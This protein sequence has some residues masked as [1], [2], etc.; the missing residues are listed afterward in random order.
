MYETGIGGKNRTQHALLQMLYNSPN[1]LYLLK[2]QT[3]FMVILISD[4]GIGSSPPIQTCPE[5][6]TTE[7]IFSIEM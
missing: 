2:N 4:S 3:I 6:K 1:L 7:L 5:E